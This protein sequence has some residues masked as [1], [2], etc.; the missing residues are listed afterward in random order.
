MAGDQEAVPR[1]RP[2]Q[3]LQRRLKDQVA[4]PQRT[5]PGHDKLR[6]QEMTTAAAKAAAKAGFS[7]KPAPDSSS[8]INSRGSSI[9]STNKSE[10]NSAATNKNNAGNIPVAGRNRAKTNGGGLPGSSENGS[11]DASG[12]VLV[13]ATRALAASQRDNPANANSNTNASSPLRDVVSENG[14]KSGSS[15]MKS[16]PMNGSSPANG[17]VMTK[18][19]PSGLPVIVSVPNEPAVMGP[20]SNDIR[21]ATAA[22]S[23]AFKK[24]MLQDKEEKEKEIKAQQLLKESQDGHAQV[25]D[26]LAIPQVYL[27]EPDTDYS[28]AASL[29]SHE[30]AEKNNALSAAKLSVMQQRPL[31]VL[32]DHLRPDSGSEMDQQFTIGAAKLAAHRLST[33]EHD[34][35]SILSHIYGAEQNPKK[36]IDIE[37]EQLKEKNALAAAMAAKVNVDDAVE[38]INTAI[39]SKGPSAQKAPRKVRYQP[40]AVW[41]GFH[42]TTLREGSDRRAAAVDRNVSESARP[43]LLTLASVQNMSSESVGG[44]RAPR[45]SIDTDSRVRIGVDN[46]DD[47]NAFIENALEKQKRFLR[48]HPLGTEADTASLASTTPA[49]VVAPPS[50]SKRKSKWGG[51]LH[52]LMNKSKE[53]ENK[54]PE[55]PEHILRPTMRKDPKKSF[56]E[57]KPWKHHRNALIVTEKE[58]KRYEGVWAANK[59][60]QVPYLYFGRLDGYESDEEEQTG[61]HHRHIGSGDVSDHHGF[62]DLLNSLRHHEDGGEER[63]SAKAV[64]SDEDDDYEDDDDEDDDEDYDDD[65]DDY[66]YYDDDDFD[67]ADEIKDAQ[68]EVHGLVCRDLWRRSRLP[69]QTLEHIWSLVDKTKDGS[70]DRDSFL[71]GMWLVDQCLYG[72]KLPSKVDAQVWNSVARLS[73]K[74]RVNKAADKKQR[75]QDRKRTK[76]N[77][78]KRRKEP[79]LVV[80]HPSPG[81]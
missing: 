48:E 74:I 26:Y 51:M 6:V 61:H 50:G 24:K 38:K 67:Y 21:S 10:S 18:L 39:A 1:A 31:S 19:G 37:R 65:D 72:R 80:L 28:D 32:S 15:G 7:K 27:S 8:A 78:K 55:A 11:L 17:R 5:P 79:R 60:L 49:P 53:K 64:Y 30:V 57:D 36:S 70:L 68:D 35:D 59:G 4:N 76:K 44:I 71:V 58:K 23:L 34:R 13:A 33:D 43:S 22:S 29:V 56:N 73:L 20:P 12:D 75:K 69:D 2:N 3:S 45:A 52:K 63:K 81:D 77:K 46:P 41:S 9:R 25:A 14:S 66:D 16:S 54:Q 62:R 47:R 42:N 40:A